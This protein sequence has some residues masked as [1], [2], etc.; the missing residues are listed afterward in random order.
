MLRVGQ[1]TRRAGLIAASVLGAG[2]VLLLVAMAV[3]PLLLPAAELRRVAAQALAGSTG[4]EVEIL[5]EPAIRLFPS[6]RVVLG[7]VSFPLSAG[8]SLD[9]ENVVTRLDLIQLLAGR[10]AVNDVIVEHPTLVLTGEGVAPALGIASVLAATDRP[11]LRIVDGTIAWRSSSG[12]T[13]ELVSGITASLDRV[14]DHAGIAVAIQF[15]W[16]E[17]PVNGTLFIDDITAFMAGTPAPLRIA[18]ATDGAKARFQGRGALGRSPVMSPVMD[19]TVSAEA[20][21]LRALFDWAGVDA[22]TR[23]GFGAFSLVS[24]LT[25]EKGEVALADASVAL[26]GNRGDGGLLVKVSGPRPLIQGTFAA[27]R[28]SLA[29]YGAARLTANDR[30]GWDRGPIDLSGLGY[31]DLDLRLSAARVDV[32]DTEFST[33][34]ASAV[35]SGGRLVVALGEARGWGG[36]LRAS[37]TLVPAAP[38]VSGAGAIRPAGAE[39][40]IEAEATDVDLARALDDVGGFRR[41]DGTGSVQIDVA[42][43]GRTIEG[44][45]ANLQGS[46]SLTAANGYLNGFDVALL[47]QRIERRPLS[48]V[49][50][51]RGGRTG[52][53]ELNGR[54]AIGDGIGTVEEL[55]MRGAKAQIDMTGSL[56]I[57]QRTLDLVGHASLPATGST[58]AG[59]IDLPFS[60]RGPWDEPRIMADPLSLI[61]RSGAALPLLEAVKNRAPGAE[62]ERALD[63]RAAPDARQAPAN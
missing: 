7:K 36:L 1:N 33:V 46:A 19:G 39:V 11:E 35:L 57:A 59:G 8:Q 38:D 47:L 9:A 30:Q 55:A 62:A 58:R 13:R 23:N 48:A 14:L 12:L 6:P 3:L 4:Q 61:E 63:G 51:W 53:A 41:I 34:A 40:R 22:P 49:S 15:D 54:I 50:D 27:D 5:G 43:A 29:P 44:I 60:V 25:L 45:A 31:C 21:S 2:A 56:S 24:R 37:L 52:F 42:G 28:I 17:Q 20:D 16:R 10:V 26:D 18:L 32:G